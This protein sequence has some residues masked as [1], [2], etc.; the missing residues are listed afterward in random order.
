MFGVF[1]IRM[2]TYCVYSWD[3]GAKLCY[4]DRSYILIQHTTRIIKI[5]FIVITYKLKED[6]RNV[7]RYLVEESCAT[8]KFDLQLE[9][10]LKYAEFRML[11]L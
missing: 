5:S 3:G 11:R 1:N 4:S 8:N 9:S 6:L 7:T 2:A 10:T